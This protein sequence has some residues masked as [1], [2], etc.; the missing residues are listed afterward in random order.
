MTADNA[1][2]QLW[3]SWT[4]AER[5]ADTDA[6]DRLLTAE[7]RGVGPVG[8]VLGKA[9]W[10]RRYADG[11]AHESIAL[12]EVETRETDDTAVAI[13]VLTQT[14]SYRGHRTDGRFRVTLIG[15]RRA[16]GWRLDGLHL[17]PIRTAA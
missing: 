8:F 7:F 12:D 4:E 5:D 11:L 1:V 9:E 14:S 10:L 2:A 16:Q 3:R 6:L 17:S 15:R 13:G